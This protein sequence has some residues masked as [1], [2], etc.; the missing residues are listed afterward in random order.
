ML[1]ICQSCRCRCVSEWPAMCSSSACRAAFHRLIR[2]IYRDGKRDSSPAPERGWGCC[3]WGWWRLTTAEPVLAFWPLKWWT[4]DGFWKQISHQQSCRNTR[5]KGIRVA[6]S[7]CVFHAQCW[8]SHCRR[9]HCMSEL[10]CC[11]MSK[12]EADDG[13]RAM[14]M[15]MMWLRAFCRP[16]NSVSFLTPIQK[17]AFYALTS[18]LHCVPT[19]SRISFL[20][21]F[22]TIEMWK[23]YGKSKF[24]AF[25]DLTRSLPS[26]NFGSFE[27]FIYALNGKLFFRLLHKTLWQ[28]S[29]N[30]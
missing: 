7:S 10:G 14:K 22:M 26:N 21:N 9:D 6:W 12:S 20:F 28:E 15:M 29:K 18:P 30:F 11:R 5:P 16:M 2:W 17:G 24:P 4:N 3:C 27:S 25:W 8:R 13:L 1:F 23:V 19:K